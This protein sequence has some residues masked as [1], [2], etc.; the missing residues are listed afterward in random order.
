MGSRGPL[1][2]SPDQARL[3]GRK[4]STVKTTVA[5]PPANV[6][7]MPSDLPPAGRKF[8]RAVIPRLLDLDLVSDLD[9][10]ALRDMAICYARLEEAE[11]DVARRGLLIEG[12]R[13]PVKNPAC[14]L[15]RE[16]RR[17]FQAWAARFGLTTQDRKRIN[18]EEE[19]DHEENPILQLLRMQR[20]AETRHAEEEEEDERNAA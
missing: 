3:K 1:P 10:P 11:A 2:E 4:A 15:A 12:D 13:G 17:A 19:P 5:A 9:R 20:E 6:L 7:K 16:Y 18:V 14:Q 8:W